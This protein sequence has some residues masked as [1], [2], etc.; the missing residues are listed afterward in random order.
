MRQLPQAQNIL[1]QTA[2]RHPERPEPWLELCDLA[3]AAEDR[4]G[5]HQFITEAEKR[6]ALP[7]LLEPRKKQAGVY[8][9]GDFQ[10]QRTIIR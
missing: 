7:E 5:A 4:T 10:P 3:L 6:N 2:Q 1:R 9:T 8:T